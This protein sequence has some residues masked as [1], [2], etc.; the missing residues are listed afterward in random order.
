MLHHLHLG[1]VRKM[2]VGL[3]DEL[4]GEDLGGLDL[5]HIKGR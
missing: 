2:R 4:R 3:A 1:D 5:R